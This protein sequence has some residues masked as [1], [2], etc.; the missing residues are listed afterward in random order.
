MVGSW[1]GL[2]AM[3]KTN[4]G[5]AAMLY[6]W[7]EAFV[8]FF[9]K[10]EF[11]S[12]GAGKV[13]DWFEAFSDR[14]Y[15]MASWSKTKAWSTLCEKE[16]GA[17]PWYLRPFGLLRMAV[18]V[19]PQLN[20]V[21]YL[22]KNQKITDEVLKALVHINKMPINSFVNTYGHPDKYKDIVFS[23]TMFEVIQ[24]IIH[25]EHEEH[26][27]Q[28]HAGLEAGLLVEEKSIWFELMR[29]LRH[30]NS[31]SQRWLEVV[32]L[33]SQKVPHQFDKVVH[34]QKTMWDLV[35]KMLEPEDFS[36]LK[37]T[38]LESQLLPSS[39]NNGPSKKVRL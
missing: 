6:E 30:K 9:E 21:D 8:R 20:V 31:N 14:P 26:E 35:G 15:L 38:W 12:F 34:N 1:G 36:R 11:S 22:N 4:P 19:N 37:Q 10:N 7:K 13:W 23:E 2:H 27:R 25:Q 32:T 29:R 33:A 18:K 17:I 28:K 5:Y 24:W 3:K 16:L 39:E